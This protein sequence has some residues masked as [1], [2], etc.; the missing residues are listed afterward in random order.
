MTENRPPGG[1]SRWPVE[2]AGPLALENYPPGALDELIAS[3]RKGVSA[4]LRNPDFVRRYRA[5]LKVHPE[6]T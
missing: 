6:W 2:T 4:A 1:G 3:I 5:W